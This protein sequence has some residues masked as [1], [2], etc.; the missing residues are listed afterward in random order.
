MLYNEGND[1]RE[2]GDFME[3]GTDRSTRNVIVT[4]IK[5]HGTRSVAELAQELGVTEMAVRR[6]LHVL[7]R[8]GLVTATLVRQAMGRPMNIYSLTAAADELFPKKYHHLALD[9]LE[10][11]DAADV[12]ALFEKR[13]AKLYERYEGRMRG[14]TLPER[15]QELAGIQNANGYMVQWHEA[16]P[17]QYELSE[18]NC[19][20]AQVA[21]PYQQA[22]S[23]EL[24]LFRQLLQADVERTE[25]LA[26]GGGKCVYRIKV[27]GE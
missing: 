6:H 20:I 5:T 10:E 27:S 18:H 1:R 26:K 17:G 21:T 9:L 8:D 25:C 11:L 24:A 23:C 7:E 13:K 22:C 16:E 12:E 4:L 2:A 14:K 3:Q 19:P 15:V